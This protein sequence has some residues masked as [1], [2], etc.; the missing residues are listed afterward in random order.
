MGNE[1]KVRVKNYSQFLSGLRMEWMRRLFDVM[2]TLEEDQA[3][4]RIGQDLD[5]LW[6]RGQ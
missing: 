2:G 1:I 3:S 5:M 4:D 6:L